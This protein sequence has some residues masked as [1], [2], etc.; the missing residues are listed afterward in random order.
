MKAK[1]LR[2]LNS[3]EI[4]S[5]LHQLEEELFSLRI[6][7]KTTDITNTK[8]FRNIR[9][10]IARIKTIINDRKKEQEN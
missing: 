10:D 3:N 8:Q 2:E 7:S 1:D 5:R 9:R 4:E 6:K